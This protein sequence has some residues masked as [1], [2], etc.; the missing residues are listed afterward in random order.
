MS[1]ATEISYVPSPEVQSAVAA[2]ALCFLSSTAVL[3]RS[4]ASSAW[5]DGSVEALKVAKEIDLHNFSRIEDSEAARVF[6]ACPSARTINAYGCR[7]LGSSS[8]K[9]IAE[10]CH[11]L[12]TLNLTSNPN[13]TVP[14]LDE[15]VSSCSDLNYLGLAG[16]DRIP[17]D[18]L[19]TKY[20]A[21]VDIFDEEEEGPW[22]A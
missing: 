7:R 5:R 11:E 10:T 22:T 15:I 14:M 17:E 8:F 1:S 3:A 13:I 2:N 4:A 12:H 16:C 21:L 6:F 19:R 9:A 18:K 20:A